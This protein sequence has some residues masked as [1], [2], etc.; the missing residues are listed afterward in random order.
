MVVEAAAAA[1]AAVAAAAAAAS[2]TGG[3]NGNLQYDT[4][5]CPPSGVANVVA[6]SPEFSLIA[7]HP[8]YG[9]IANYMYYPNE[10]EININD[11]KV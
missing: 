6:G 3:A 10:P 1:A 7:S 8:S 11:K 9:G 4:P 5:G 2:A